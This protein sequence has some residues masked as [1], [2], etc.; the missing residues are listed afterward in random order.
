MRI[1]FRFYPGPLAN[2]TTTLALTQVD[3]PVGTLVNFKRQSW[4]D[5]ASYSAILAVSENVLK[6]LASSI[7]NYFDLSQQDASQY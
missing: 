7:I 2:S 3:V 4:T 5:A 6:G 1:F